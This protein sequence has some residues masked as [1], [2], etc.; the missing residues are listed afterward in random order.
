MKFTW[1]TGIFLFL[2]VFL[3]AAASFIIFA[4][5]QDVNLVHEDYYEKGADYTEQMKV[6]ARSA[7]FQGAIKTS[8]DETHYHVEFH[9]SP[10]FAIDSGSVQ[11]YRPSD[12]DLDLESKLSG[13]SDVASFPLEELVA[14]RYILKVSWYTEGLK[15]EIEEAV[16]IQ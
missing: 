13:S 15:Y 1:G 11:L 8:F 16:F 10:E 4:F 2:T 6:D 9:H 12:S 7:K 3:L 14:G 5:R